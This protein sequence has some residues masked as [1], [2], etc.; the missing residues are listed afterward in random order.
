MNES[1]SCLRCGSIT[2]ST[3]SSRGLCPRCASEVETVETHPH[4]RAGARPAEFNHRDQAKSA[5]ARRVSTGSP[6]ERLKDYELLQ[7][8]GRGGVGVVYKARQIS[9]QREVALKMILAGEFAEEVQ[10]KRFHAEAEAA[11]HLDHPNI[12]SIYEIGEQ[13]GRHFFTMKLVHGESLVRKIPALQSDPRSGVIMLVKIARAV[14]YAHQRGILHRDLKPANILVD[15]Q[16]EPHV[17]DF[18]L[19]TR[20]HSD[21]ALTISGTILGTPAYMSPEQA[22]GQTKQLTTATDIYSLGS[23]LYHLIAG[24]PPFTG[25]SAIKILRRVVDEEPTPLRQVAPTADPDLETICLKC[26]EKDPTRRYG[27]AEAL[28]DDLERWL[29]FEPIQA[30]PGTPWQKSVK[31]V[32]RKPIVAALLALLLTAIGLGFAGVVSQWT[33]AERNAAESRQRL[34]RL[35]VINGVYLAKEGDLSGALLWYVEALRLDAERNASQDIH[36]IRIGSILQQTP[37]L[38]RVWFHDRAV[39]LAQLSPKE[40]RLAMISGHDAVANRFDPSELRIWDFASGTPLSPPIFFS[41]GRPPMYRIRYNVFSPDGLKIVTIQSEDLSSGEVVSKISILDA[42]SGKPLVPT[43]QLEGLATHAEFSPNGQ[44]LVAA[45]KS[46]IARIWD[47]TRN[48]AIVRDLPHEAWV[49]IASFSQDNQYVLTGSMDRTA[50]IWDLKSNLAPIVLQHGRYVLDAQFNHA[51]TQIV[52]AASDMNGGEFRVWDARTGQAVCSLDMPQGKVEGVLYQ[53]SFSPDDTLIAAANFAG[54]VTIWDAHTGRMVL[55]PFKHNHGVLTAQFAPDGHRVLSASFDKTA[56]LWTTRSGGAQLAVLNHCSFLLGASFTRDGQQIITASTDGMVRQWRLPTESSSNLTMRHRNE[57]LHAEFSPDGQLVLTA[58]VDHTAR[59]WDART[60][61]PVL[62]PLQHQGAVYH[63]T[64]SPDSQWIATASADGTA[65]LWDAKTGRPTGPGLQHSNTVWRVQFDSA[66]KRVV[67]ASGK[68]RRL[69]AAS[70]TLLRDFSGPQTPQTDQDGEARVWDVQ[71]GQPLTPPLVHQ[72]AVV[73]AAFSPTANAVI[74]TSADRTAQLWQL[75][76][77]SKTGPAMMHTGIVFRA[78]FSPDGR[79]IATVTGGEGR[80]IKGAAMLWK[81]QNASKAERIFEH[82]D[83]VYAAN[84]SR[85]GRR[86]VTASEDGTARV[87][88]VES[89]AP[90][91]PPLINGSIVLG[92]EFSPDGRFVLL[93]S[94][95]GILRVWEAAT[96][97]LISEMRLHEK[98]INASVLSPDG[99]NILSVSDDGTAKITQ[100]P[101]TEFSVDDLILLSQTLA[102][103]R[104]PRQ[105]THLEPLEEQQF[106][107]AWMRLCQRLPDHFRFSRSLDSPTQNDENSRARA[108]LK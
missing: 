15:S 11:A 34:T 41:G 104:I 60:G 102:A 95:D 27:S 1:S 105:G 83:I 24:K 97:E 14:H 89:G 36:R 7:E 108:E 48:G 25:E 4:D 31:W 91:T 12:V 16:G 40:D 98:R 38:S 33:R 45:G 86:L 53:A 103:R 3:E 50:K 39:W 22:L 28:A 13:D 21:T 84:F 23:I 10:I 2:V 78:S 8:L 5:E 42:S 71:T 94:V 76:E 101:F 79:W 99:R 85:D 68:F 67:T 47:L 49:T 64:F 6:G 93:S 18:G 88:D 32:R 87:W 80:L 72:D 59:V 69:A 82:G 19:A 77:G 20:L 55:A 37:Q 54:T 29:R 92:A 9:L 106:T 96:G 63:A 17:T 62:P 44:F 51:G 74:T 46:G 26:L 70:S 90:I 43:L 100:L 56:R 52:T 107:D 73:F 65:R 57:V 75:P 61:Q 30:R 81:A 66:G 58:S 35:N